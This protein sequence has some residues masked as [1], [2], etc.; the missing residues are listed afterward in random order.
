MSASP[1]AG[2]ILAGGHS[3][4][5][6]GLDAPPKPL[7]KIDGAPMVLHVADGLARGGARRIIVLT[8][9]R[10]EAIRLGLG[11]IGNHG[12]LSV[13][14]GCGIPFELRYSGENNGTA[15]RLLAIEPEEFGSAALLTYTDV[16]SDA[17]LA[18]LLSLRDRYGSTLSMLTVNP[19]APW[20]VVDAQDEVV[21]GFEEKPLEHSKWINGGI[22]AVT[23]DVL[24]AIASATEMLE[25]EPMQRLIAA[26]KVT[27]LRYSGAW[28]AVDTPKDL[29]AMHEGIVPRDPSTLPRLLPS[30]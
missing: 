10:H 7:V 29:R 17:P 13:G 14:N 6:G 9:A 28:S 20:G 1:P 26:R 30:A 18:S 16:I 2:I 4:R 15:G 27:A 3:E 21:V 23:A 24:E 8:G 11:L 5:F 12:V 19:R 25:A 22:F